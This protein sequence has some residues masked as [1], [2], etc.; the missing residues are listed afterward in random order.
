MI[1]L[2]TII[3][4]LAVMYLLLKLM[5]WVTKMWLKISIGVLEVA[6]VI[7]ALSILF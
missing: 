3:A 4:Y 5:L 2:L 1:T 7:S 6:L